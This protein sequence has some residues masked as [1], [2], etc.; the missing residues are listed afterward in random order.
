MNMSF[1]VT[2]S[3]FRIVLSLAWDRYNWQRAV[4]AQQASYIGGL[5]WQPGVT[6]VYFLIYFQ[7]V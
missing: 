1:E 6:L 5:V 7:N 2:E 3:G 4:K